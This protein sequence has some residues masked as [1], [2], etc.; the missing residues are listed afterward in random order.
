[1]TANFDRVARMYR[2][3][4]YAALGPLLS[5][6]RNF[7]LPQL[8]E[9]RCALILGDGDGRFTA[10]LLAANAEMHADVV[11]SS[12]A[13]LALLRSRC[14][15]ERV[16]IHHGDAL[17]YEPQHEVDLVVAHFF[18]DCFTQDELNGL[19]ARI[20]TA[21]RPDALW[22]VSDFRVPAGAM[23]W[24]AQAYIQMLYLAFRVLTGLR[25]MRLPDYAAAL[26]AAGLAPVA[27][28]R[29]LFGI[30]TTELWQRGK[31]E[32]GSDLP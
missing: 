10:R 9:C 6:C 8:G 28:H 20:A 12:G 14:G 11:D 25:I 30:L 27:I 23:H 15:E 4:E 17:C 32:S 29:S 1:M 7:Y 31:C 22:V 2:W 24:P 3:A 13:M 5:R 21:V 16:R 18:F 19:V 26:R